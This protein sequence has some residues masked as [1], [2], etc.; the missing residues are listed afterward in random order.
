LQTFLTRVLDLPG[1]R[2]ALKVEQIAHLS[3][4]FAKFEIVVKEVTGETIEKIDAIAEEG[5]SDEDAIDIDD[6]GATLLTD[7]A[8][9]PLIPSAG[10]GDDALGAPGA[11]PMLL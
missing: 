9:A 6:V 3:D 8:D 7:D 4:L 5:S 1:E 2:G 10:D 11:A